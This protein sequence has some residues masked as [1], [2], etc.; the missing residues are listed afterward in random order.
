M[1]QIPLFKKARQPVS[2]PRLSDKYAAANMS[3][4]RII[5]QNRQRYAGVMVA[6]AEMIAEPTAQQLGQEAA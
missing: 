6:W 4:A 5:L 3:A 2:L 1:T